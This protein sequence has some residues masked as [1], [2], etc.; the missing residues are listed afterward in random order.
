[1][2]CFVLRSQGG[3]KL[4]SAFP[5]G[6]C[7]IASVITALAHWE[8]KRAFLWQ[9]GFI[10]KRT[11]PSHYILSGIPTT[12]A[13]P[14]ARILKVAAIRCGT[15]A[16]TC[17]RS[18]NDCKLSVWHR[19]II[20]GNHRLCAKLWN[21]FWKL[22]EFRNTSFFHSTCKPHCVFVLLSLPNCDDRLGPLFCR[23]IE[24]SA[25]TPKSHFMLCAC[26]AVSFSARV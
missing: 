11:R 15:R 3:N 16:W 7:A 10:S 5:G 24:F 19:R 25:I 17:L 1:M 14:H 23:L 8:H 21:H 4:R 9:W 12:V 18:W 22:G 6:V 13:S 26:N 20:A 2:C